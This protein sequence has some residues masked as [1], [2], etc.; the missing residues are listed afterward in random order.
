MT[1][2]VFPFILNLS[3]CKIL[4]RSSL[5]SRRKNQDRQV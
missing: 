5:R 1:T 4:K 2:D 3:H